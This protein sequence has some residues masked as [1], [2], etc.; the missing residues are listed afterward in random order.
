MSVLTKADILG[1]DDRK[2]VEVEVPE[3]GG[4]VLVALM[5]GEARDC[6]E[7]ESYQSRQRGEPAVNLRARIAARCMVDADGNR[8][9]GE[10]DIDALGKKSGAALDRVFDVACRVNKIGPQDI[11]DLEGNSSA[12]LSGSSTSDSH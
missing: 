11:D 7:F 6:F 10:S 9:F 1:A 3:W 8:L 12:D 5:S 4:T 2:P